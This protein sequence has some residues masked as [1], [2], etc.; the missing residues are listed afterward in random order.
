[1]LPVA[2]ST[3]FLLNI[4]N[5]VN[6]TNS[7]KSS[8]MDILESML[9]KCRK[10]TIDSFKPDYQNT[11]S[12]RSKNRTKGAHFFLFAPETPPDGRSARENLDE[13]AIDRHSYSI[14]WKSICARVSFSFLPN[15]TKAKKVVSSSRSKCTGLTCF[16]SYDFILLI[17]TFQLL[18]YPITLYDISRFCFFISTSNV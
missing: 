10:K 6:F 2:S 7:N 4:C 16:C 9:G 1:M 18:N 8:Y 11:P 15:D 5:F 14:G 13:S 3:P 12:T 17:T